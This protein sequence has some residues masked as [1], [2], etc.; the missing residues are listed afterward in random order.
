MAVVAFLVLLFTAWMLY[1]WFVGESNDVRWLRLCC[2]PT[3]VVMVAVISAA[4]GAG[5]ALKVTKTSVRTDVAALLHAIEQRVQSGDPASVV[6]ELRQLDH[7]GDPDADAF[8]LLEDLPLVTQRLNSTP[9]RGAV[10]QVAEA[11]QT[12]PR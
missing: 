2:A 7:T 6:G 1:G 9:A 8:D 3:V 5:I 11:A 4:A 10:H 12:E